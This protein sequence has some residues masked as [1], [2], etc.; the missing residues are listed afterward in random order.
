MATTAAARTR[1]HKHLHALGGFLSLEHCESFIEQRQPFFAQILLDVIGG[2]L[3]LNGGIGEQFGRVQAAG[4]LCRLTRA[5]DA[6]CELSSC[7]RWQAPSM[8]STFARS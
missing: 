7:I 6:L 5:Y 3:K 1:Q 4:K 8:S 2:S